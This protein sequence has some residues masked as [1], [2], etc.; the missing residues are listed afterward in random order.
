MQE[1]FSQESIDAGRASTEVAHVPADGISRDAMS[2][3]VFVLS[4]LFAT[5]GP[6]KHMIHSKPSA[7]VPGTAA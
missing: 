7:P 1:C 5:V 6:R 2:G 3:R 4:V